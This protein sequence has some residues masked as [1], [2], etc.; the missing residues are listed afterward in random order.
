M[1][2][3]KEELLAALEGVINN[4]N[5]QLNENVRDPFDY[6]KLDQKRR[7][8]EEV[9]IFVNEEMKAVDIKDEKTNK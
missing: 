5:K 4:L 2:I 7:A 3:S 6:V 9:K 1:Y 8:F